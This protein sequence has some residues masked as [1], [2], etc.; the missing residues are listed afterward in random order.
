VWALFAGGVE[1]LEVFGGAGGGGGDALCAT[2][3]AGGCGSFLVTVHH[4]WAR[5]YRFRATE[6]S[7][8][9]ASKIYASRSSQRPNVLDIDEQ[10]Q[11]H[12]QHP[13]FEARLSPL[14][15][16]QHELVFTFRIR[17]STVF[18]AA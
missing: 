6:I 15:S 1:V 16:S 2:L 11:L 8:P 17:G 9:Q 10:I 14:L 13:L 3:Y 4:P 18:A 5:L 7:L 12:E